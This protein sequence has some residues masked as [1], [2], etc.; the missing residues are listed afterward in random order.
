MGESSNTK[1]NEVKNT[2]WSFARKISM[3]L[4][5]GMALNNN[6]ALSQENIWSH[7]NQQET[8]GIVVKE[9]SNQL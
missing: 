6:P 9:E 2:L 1:N 3:V 7:N 8:I 5:F 4:W